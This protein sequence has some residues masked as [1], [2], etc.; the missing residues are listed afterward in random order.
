MHTVCS[1]VLKTCCWARQKLTLSHLPS[2]GSGRNMWQQ[3]RNICTFLG[4]SPVL[5]RERSQAQQ[6]GRWRC[7]SG[8]GG[9]WQDAANIQALEVLGKNHPVAQV[10]TDIQQEYWHNSGRCCKSGVKGWSWMVEY[11]PQK[12]DWFSNLIACPQDEVSLF[13]VD[14]EDCRALMSS[15]CLGH[16]ENKVWRFG[17]L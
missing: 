9:F 4:F 10:N 6:R 15:E 3:G 16:Y 14:L 5:A 1:G 11:L 13:Q 17:L 12:G 2:S 7:A 8:L